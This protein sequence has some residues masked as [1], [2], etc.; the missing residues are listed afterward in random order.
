[1]SEDISKIRCR[2]RFHCPPL[3]PAVTGRRDMPPTAAPTSRSRRFGT[4][5]R[6]CE[7]DEADPIAVGAVG[8]GDGGEDV[9]EVAL[10]Y[11]VWPLA[12]LHLRALQSCQL[13]LREHDPRSLL[14]KVSKE[15]NAANTARSCE[16]VE[17]AG[18]VEGRLGENQSLCLF[19]THAV[20]HEELHERQNF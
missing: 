5:A 2:R 4:S 14:L 20:G 9:V 10:P 11:G 19:Q 1:M 6:T 16:G 3:G 15:R 18:L 17:L 7:E 13:L 12:D 8:D